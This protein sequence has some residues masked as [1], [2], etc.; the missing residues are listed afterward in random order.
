[1]TS[2]LTKSILAVALAASS[3]SVSAY[4]TGTNN[5]EFTNFT[6]YKNDASNG[7]LLGYTDDDGV[8]GPGGGGQ[9][10]DTEY[11]FIKYDDTSHN[12][13]IGLQTGFDINSDGHL[14]YGNKSYYTGDLA[15]SFDGDNSGYE[16]AIDFGFLTKDYYGN[17][18]DAVSS[19]TG[20]TGTYGVDAAGVYSVNSW[21]NNILH[22]DSGPFA[23][24]DGAY[25][26]GFTT[27]TEGKGFSDGVNNS[28]YDTSY[29]KV[30]TFD[31]STILDSNELQNFTVSANW[32]MSCGND[33]INTEGT[34]TSNNP[35]PVPEPSMMMLMG[36][37]SLTILAS[38]LRR[39][40]VK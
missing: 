15:L 19:G 31:L 20:N 10:F 33:A 6:N 36:I 16:Y 14:Y 1:M 21:N 24:D 5:R 13:S 34:Y 23:V 35:N 38:G 18:V 39:R 27:E 25:V 40:K 28:G 32:T 17:K 3:L 11:L 7:A 37:G 9:R 8:I 26:T 12:L 30:V 29:Y 2:R 4:D 22:P